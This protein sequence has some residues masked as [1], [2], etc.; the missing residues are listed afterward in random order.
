M[1]R[2]QRRDESMRERGRDRGLWPY[3]SMRMRVCLFGI[4]LPSS[5]CHFLIIIPSLVYVLFLSYVCGV[6]SC[7]VCMSGYPL[8]LCLLLDARHVGTMVV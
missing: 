2:R 8:V 1:S 5:F 4:S 6:Q 3:G 7:V